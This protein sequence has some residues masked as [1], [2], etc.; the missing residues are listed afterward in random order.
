MPSNLRTAGFPR[1]GLFVLLGLAF[2]YALSFLLRSLWGYS[3]ALDGESVLRIAL[4]STPLFFLVGLG[5]FDYWFYWAAGRPTRPED[6]SNHGAHSWK[7]YFKV[8]TDHKV[9]GTQYVVNSFFF[10]LVG[11]LMAMLMRAELA[12]P[13]RQFIDANTYNGVFSVHASLLIF[14][15]IIPVFAGLANFVLP[16]M[17]GAPD[18]AFPRLNALSFWMLPVAGTMML[19]SF[20]AP[21]GSFASGWTAYAPL[22]TSAP[23]GQEF[24]T[25][26]VQFAG[27]SSIATALNFLV[28]I[29]TMRAPGMSFFRMPL[30]V[31][32]NFA[33]SLLV[34]IATPF[35]AASQFFVLLDRGLGF[36]FFQTQ[37]GAGGDVLMY[38]HVFWFYSHPAVY[39]MM[40]PGFG[41]VSEVLA[42]KS[43]KPIFGYR[44]MCFSL[45]AIVVLGFTVW[46]HHMF[47]SGMQG[48]I[49]VPMM[50]TTAI[51]AVPTGIKIFSW[52]ATLWRGVLKLD[53]P[54]LFV[55][56]FLTMF[57]LGGISGVMLAMIPLTIH[58]SD[59]YFIVAH[60]HYVLFGGSLFTIFAGVY[61][62][63]PKMTG[64]MYD[65]TL[66]KL[67]FWLTFIFF[68]ATFAPMH[69]IGV[70]GMPRRVA[71]YAEAFANWNLFISIASFILGLSTLIFVYNMVASWRGGARAPA[72]PWR[73]LTLEWQVS[74]PPPIFNFDQ[75]PTVVGGPYEYGVPGAVHGVF[76]GPGDGADVPAGKPATVEAPA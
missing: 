10:L 12:Q 70:K 9:I 15:F 11:G 58:V 55:L 71:D 16:L 3:P 53:T 75:I 26:G 43:R 76:T 46:A 7:D 41:I 8:N 17:I 21:G 49:R 54:M 25:I 50:V 33:T 14:L 52:L 35:V 45:L 22:S 60:I 20:F 6:H 69:L 38:Q 31:W 63:F 1:A 56:G 40:L 23:L 30:L 57:T 28:T 34:V 42:V 65:E 48:W 66:G 32:A 72:N 64:R 51:I 44:M 74:S 29:I 61:Y 67:H 39:I 5:A 62:W 4:L 37:G 18:M 36:N 24:F 13:G 73:S 47:V 68:N 59:T 2:S 27:A 19:L